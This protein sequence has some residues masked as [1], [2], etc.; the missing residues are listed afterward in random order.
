MTF[1]IVRRLLLSSGILLLPVV[2]YA[3]E[4]TFT[5]TVTDSTGGVLPGVVVTAVLEA[6]GNTFAAVTDDRG[7]YRI[8]A[9]V[10]AY[11][12][13]MLACTEPSAFNQGC[14]RKRGAGHDIGLRHGR[15][16]VARCAHLDRSA[17][18]SRQ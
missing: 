15:L 1:R 2:A 6:T 12:I 17:Q 3:Q 7:V 14:L 13:D 4:A 10:G 16:A 8:P 9:R 5:G 18:L 11:K